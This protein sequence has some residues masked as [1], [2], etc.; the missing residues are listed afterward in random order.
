M[1]SNITGLLKSKSPP[2]IIIETTSGI[3]Y[4]ID[5][6]MTTF[7]Q[8]PTLNE[9]VSLF[10]HFHVREDA[11]LLFGFSTLAERQTFRVLI[12]IS[13]I[14][15]KTALALLS[16]LSSDELSLATQQNDINLITKTPGIGQKTAE[17]LL[18][19]LR[20]KLSRIASSDL[21]ASHLSDQ[22]AHVKDQIKQA[23][24]SLGYNEKEVQKTLS[25]LPAS[26]SLSVS[27]GIRVALQ[28]MKNKT[29]S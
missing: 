9:E 14:G 13:G 7:Y 11:H 4:E 28:N 3:S 25:M 5:V 2:Q 29:L 15:T 23:L 24:I 6:S 22:Q 20:N 1:I 27:E 17:R 18:L 12:K 10:T 8:L 26:D 21:S 19:E 16:T